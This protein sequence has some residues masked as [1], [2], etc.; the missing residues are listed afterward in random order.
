VNRV[1][2]MRVRDDGDEEIVCGIVLFHKKLQWAEGSKRCADNLLNIAFNIPGPHGELKRLRGVDDP[3]A[4]LKWAPF[5]LSNAYVYITEPY[6]DDDA[7][8]DPETGVFTGDENNPPL[9]TDKELDA[10]ENLGIACTDTISM[11]GLQVE[12]TTPKDDV[13]DSAKKA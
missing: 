9:P 10:V 5:R 3:E 4:W 6:D 11:S 12:L 13:A 7:L 8:Y 1:D 2:E